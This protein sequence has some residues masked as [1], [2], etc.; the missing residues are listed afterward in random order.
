MHIKVTVEPVNEGRP[1]SEHQSVQVETSVRRGDDFLIQKVDSVMC[2]GK[3]VVFSVPVGGRL[4]LSTPTATEEI[5]YDKAQG[6]AI[7]GSSQANSEGRADHEY[8][9]VKPQD[10]RSAESLVKP[11]FEPETGSQGLDTRAAG[12]KPQPDQVNP[13]VG[14][15]GAA[16]PPT[17]AEVAA[18]AAQAKEAEDKRLKAAEMAKQSATATPPPQTGQKG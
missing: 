11:Q 4:I 12:E 13:P 10:E 1:Q 7:R 8:E 9:R 16:H 14:A 3:D 15:G 6:A 17:L 18:K 5:V 2:D